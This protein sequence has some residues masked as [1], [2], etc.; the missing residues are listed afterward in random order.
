LKVTDAPDGSG[1]FV[2]SCGILGLDSF[3]GW[4]EIC[5]KQSEAGFLFPKV[6]P[7]AP[8]S[9]SV[10]AGYTRG[11]R[12][13]LA[14]VVFFESGQFFVGATHADGFQTGQTYRLQVAILQAPVRKKWSGLFVHCVSS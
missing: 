4:G 3:V 2:M 10:G 6:G 14:L 13:C 1:Y 11:V 12:D 7:V 8:E 9:V 5:F